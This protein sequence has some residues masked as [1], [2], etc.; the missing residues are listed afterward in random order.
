MSKSPSIHV[1]SLGHSPQVA[2]F[3]I[4]ESEQSE[5]EMSPALEDEKKSVL[6][7]TSI[8]SRN[9][10]SA[11]SNIPKPT[12]TTSQILAAP[13]HNKEEDHSVHTITT[14]VAKDAKY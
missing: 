7:M 6:N 9:P 1:V 13:R 4:S 3:E 14:S 8:S 11:T 5:A 2:D 10:H 12:Y